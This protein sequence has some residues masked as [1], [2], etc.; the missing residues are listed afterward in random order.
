MATEYQH[1]LTK[2]MEFDFEIQY[3]P[4]LEN[5][6]IDAL[7]RILGKAELHGISIPS[8]VDWAQFKSDIT[9]DPQLQQILHFL[10]QDP[11]AK[12]GW[13]LFHGNLFYQGKL[14][15]PRSSSLVTKFLQEF[16][17]TPSGGH[18]G[19]LRTYNRVAAWEGICADVRQFVAVCLICQQ[20]KYET[21]SPAGLLQPLQIPQAIW[22]DISM[23]CI[24]G[25]PQS[26]GYNS[27]LVVV[28]RFSKYSHFILLS[29]PFAAKVVATKFLVHVVK[30][31]GFPRS[32]V[33]DRDRVFLSNFWSKLFRLQQTQLRRSTAYHPQTNGQSEVVN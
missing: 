21:L 5:K 10:S 18:G 11:S 26:Y 6:A 13:E 1:W 3:R 25:L 19:F 2:L 14:A 7:S 32:I 20:N 17:N 15:I 4:R 29:H 12:P 28:D 30:L 23:D 16:H 24:E 22:E 31:H 27:V 33:T 8:W 9:K